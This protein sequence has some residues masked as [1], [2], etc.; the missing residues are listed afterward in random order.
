MKEPERRT[1]AFEAELEAAWVAI[2]HVLRLLQPMA[3]AVV[4]AVSGPNAGLP[5]GLPAGQGALVPHRRATPSTAQPLG[6]EDFEPAPRSRIIQIVDQAHHPIHHR[7]NQAEAV[8]AADL[9]RRIVL[10]DAC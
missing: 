2:G 3:V 5:A 7:Q 10:V 9:R 1:I 8:H 6:E 4:V